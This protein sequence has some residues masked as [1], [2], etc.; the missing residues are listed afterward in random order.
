MAIANGQA[1]CRAVRR[2]DHAPL[3]ILARVA[4]IFALALCIPAGAFAEK[5]AL[6]VGIDKYD[7]L[8]ADKQ[9]RKAV[10]DARAFRALGFETELAENVTRRDF[11]RLWA[12]FTS[13]LAPGDVAAFFFSG[14]GVDLDGNYLIPRDVQ[15]I[16]DETSLKADAINFRDLVS[17]LRAKGV[18]VSFEIVDACR[19]NPFADTKGKSIGG[20]RGLSRPANPEGNFIMYSA[21]ERQKALDRLA[22]NDPDPNSVYTRNLLP[23]L[24]PNAGL[25]LD[26]IA[27]RVRGSVRDLALTLNHKQNPA[28]YNELNQDYY[29]GG[30]PVTSAP[31]PAKPEPVDEAAIEW[32]GVNQTSIAQLEYFLSRHGSS[33]FSGY[34]RA[35]I[36]YLKQAQTAAVASPR[37]APAPQPAEDACD[38]GLVVSVGLGREKP[39]IKPGSGQVFRDCAD[40]P[41]MVVA[42]AGSYLRG[43]TD[44]DVA[45]LVKEHGK[46]TEQY[47]KRETPQRRVTIAKP[48]AVGRFSVTFAE[49]EA[50]VAGGGC[51]TTKQPSDQGWGR[52]DR[53]VINVSW[54]DAQE[55]VAWLS[56]KTGK[57]YR[58]LS[59]AEREYVARAGTTT[60]FWWGNVI[61]TDRANYDGTYTHAGSQKGEYRAKTVPV[62]SFQ[63]NPWGLY[64]VHGNVWEWVQDCFVDSYKTAPTDG[65]AIATGDCSVRVLRG[66]SWYNYPQYLRAADRGRYTTSYRNYDLGFR[67]ARTL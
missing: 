10:N 31:L 3:R 12:R 20:T 44:A 36:A 55:Y 7:N 18:A 29:P 11:S 22:D 13:K 59:E 4:F 25:S 33:R 57:S 37:P 16:D 61:S 40:C 30:K 64:Q 50:C 51:Q 63:P 38:D 67:L 35:Q 53:P 42:P 26:D 60:Q 28:Y 32:A 46:A 17:D 21:G 66:G 39:C 54:D 8:A 15:P 24:A 43:S 6:A 5:R 1:K 9:L 27:K 41:E 49:W 45:A 2:P 47:S 48:F 23:L 19:E 65:S 58:L 14:H 62:K 34:A 56:K 52:A